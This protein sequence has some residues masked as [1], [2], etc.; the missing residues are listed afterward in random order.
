MILNLYQ[1]V[2]AGFIRESGTRVVLRDRGAFDA[3]HGAR[4]GFCGQWGC[5][6]DSGAAA[7]VESGDAASSWRFNEGVGIAFPG[8][9]I[10]VNEVDGDATANDSAVVEDEDPGTSLYASTVVPGARIA[11]PSYGRKPAGAT[12]IGIDAGEHNGKIDWQA[13]KCAGVEF[14]IICSGYGQDQEG[15]HDDRWPDNVHGATAAGAPYGVYIY[16]Y[17]DP[18]AEAGGG[19]HIVRLLRESSCKP[20]FLIY[21]DLE[22]RSLESSKK[23]PLLAEMA[24]MFCSEVSRAAYAP[25]VC[26]NTNWFNS[27]PTDPVFDAWGR[28]VAQCNIV[29]TYKGTY[30]IWQCTSDG[31]LA[32][33]SGNNGRVGLN[34]ESNSSSGHLASKTGLQ[35]IDGA[36]HFLDD[37]GNKKIGW[38]QYLLF[39]Q[40]QYYASRRAGPSTGKLSFNQAARSRVIGRSGTY[41]TRT[42]RTRPDGSTS[43]ALGIISTP[44]LDV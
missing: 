14:A 19:T 15:Q 22:E 11:I 8:E 31:Y 4:D 24:C 7:L 23:V 25:A 17:A 44:N 35:M 5:F 1:E 36:M 41:A 30:Q 42:A 21:Y 13:V 38:V 18:V 2:R 32:G 29:F 39:R 40:R 27:Y 37:V 43:K 6:D 20:E 28:W 26:A 34:Y 3:R 16:S 12:R 33:L 9:E 10:V